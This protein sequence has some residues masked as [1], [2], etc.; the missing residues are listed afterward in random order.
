M[1]TFKYK[2]PDTGLWERIPSITAATKDDLGLGD[3]DNTS[4]LDKPVSTATQDALDLKANLS[5]THVKTDLTDIADFLLESEVDA[6]IK[7]LSLPAST[8]ISTFG[9]SLIN[10][11]AASNART[12]LGLG[13]IATVAAPSGTVVGTTDTQTLSAKTLTSP[14]LNT[15]VSGTAVLDEDNMASDSSTK[16]ATQQSIK[17]YVDGKT[18]GSNGWTT[19]E[20]PAGTVN[21]STT[22]FTTSAAY[23]SSSLEVFI[24]GIS[25]KR[26]THFV[27]TTP[28]SGI[29]TMGDAPITGDIITVNYQTTSGSAGNA[30]TVDSYH[31]FDL[32]PIG[33]VIDY[34]SDTMPSGNWMLLYGQAISRTT[35]ATLFAL[36]GTVYGVGNGSTTFNLPDVRGRVVAGQDDMGGTS[37]NRLTNPG[38]TTGGIDGDVLGGTGGAETHTLLTAQMPS[39]THTLP[40][41]NI[42]GSTGG[43]IAHTD[44]GN[45]PYSTSSSGSDTAHNNVQPTIILNKI[46]KVS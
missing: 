33:A 34:T 1:A 17:A 36:I 9:A 44:T 2:N 20:T 46:M 35:Y 16:L 29:F 19:G 28:A 39:H 4:D 15:G 22:A 8:T 14:V 38:S 3:V 40:V 25:Q 41:G 21:G 11:A 37:A 32:M 43:T 10:A 6:D 30:D 45:S 7:T 13:T 24:N 42:G 27:E 23:I 31:Y 26:T 12:T 5:H 18:L